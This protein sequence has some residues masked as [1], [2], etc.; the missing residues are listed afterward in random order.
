L[1]SEHFSLFKKIPEQSIREEFA[2]FAKSFSAGPQSPEGWM[3]GLL[4][5]N[6]VVLM[7]H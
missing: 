6:S 2:S 7:T 1:T 5:G 3:V 4:A